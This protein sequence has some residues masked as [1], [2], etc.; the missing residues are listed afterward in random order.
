MIKNIIKLPRSSKQ[1]ILLLIDSFLLIGVLIASFSLRL[2][3]W[4]LPSGDLL[5]LILVA[6]LLAI[7]IFIRLDLY[8]TIIRFIGL[9][10]LWVITK[11][12]SLYA[13]IWGVLGFLSGI[14]EIPRSVVLINWLLTILIISSSRMMARWILLETKMQYNQ[15]C[16]NVVIYGAGAAGRQL[17]NALI[18]SA[19][20]N[21]IALIDDSKDIHRKKINGIQI[22]SPDNLEGLINDKNIEEVLL[23]IPSISRNRRR[24]I[25]DFLKSFHVVV[26]SLPSVSEIAQGKIK[27][28]DLLKIDI[29][30]LLGRDQVM[31]N[32]KLLSVKIT[33]KVVMVTGAG[34]SIGSEL[35]RQILDLS[36]KKIILFEISESSLYLIEQELTSNLISNI[37]IIP[38][39]GSISDKL[40]ISNILNLYKVETIYH[41][42]AYKHVPLV[43]S[44]P[45]QGVLN[46]ALGTLIIAEAAIASNVQTF[47]LIS[48]DKAVRPTSTMGVAK[49]V[50]ELV[51]QALSKKHHNTCFTMVRFGNVLDSSGSVIPLFKKQ[52]EKG[53][54][55]T[56][57]DINMVRFFMTI[58]EAVELVIQ[59]GAMAQGGDVF[60]LDMGEPVS[61][62][63][64]AIKMIQ[65]S[66]LKVRD[67]NNP[68]GDIEISYTGVRP[69]EKL[70][71]ELLVG[72]NVIKTENRL[73]MRANEIMIEWKLLEPMLD[74]LKEVS[75]TG[76]KDLIQKSLKKIVPEYNY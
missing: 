57:T 31:P 8:R 46:N 29:A 39:I 5:I 16:K 1:I 75:I 59:S 67:H 30:D 51:L 12:V 72:D 64:L 7:P 44:N 61:I 34:G 3:N 74:E 40:R 21:P 50:A 35:S 11:A 41:A 52:I 71:E 32:E 14:Q 43:E 56:V 27:I 2:G 37:E 70:Y 76:E 45:S 22:I 17:L 36:P 13:L 54:P 47:V 23:A 4:F 38:V 68:D 55:I 69:G 33:N 20:Y 15:K 62:N 10:T 53:G 60:V 6:P 9:E 65:L 49:R 66:G 58:P 73:I 42:A 63:D 25:V 18:Q 26:R 48:T 28:D 19:E 24:E